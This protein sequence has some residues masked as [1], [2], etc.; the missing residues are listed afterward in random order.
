[1][2]FIAYNDPSRRYICF[3]D[4]K[5]YTTAYGN[6]DFFEV[7]MTRDKLKQIDPGNIVYIYKTDEE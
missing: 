4:G 1:M 5:W 7:I 6:T 2:R 3:P